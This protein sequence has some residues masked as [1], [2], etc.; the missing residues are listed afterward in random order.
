MVKENENLNGSSYKE[1]K[2]RNARIWL[3]KEGIIRFMYLP[4]SE[5]TL[6]DAEENVT[7]IEKIGAG[8]KKP[9]F[10]D[11][12]THK[13]M[14]RESRIYYM[15]NTPLLGTACGVKATSPFQRV[16]SIFMSVLNKT[17]NKDGFP[18]KFFK[19]E[20]EAIIWLKKFQD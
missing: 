13:S 14:S 5:D 11:P 6:E 9:I 2:T 17:F 18:M 20:Q 8:K 10:I 19:S 12:G 15:K 3:D 7:A 4:E 1:I 16:L